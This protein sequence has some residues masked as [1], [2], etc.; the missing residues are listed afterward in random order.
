MCYFKIFNYYFYLITS[1][2]KG[3]NEGSG[4]LLAPGLMVSK[5]RTHIWNPDLTSI[6]QLGD[7]SE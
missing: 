5:W 6:L 2:N 7:F 1:Q 3:E 4:R